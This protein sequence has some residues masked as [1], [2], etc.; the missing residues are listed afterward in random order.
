MNHSYLGGRVE[1]DVETS[2]TPN[3]VV[4]NFTMSTKH[5]EKRDFH[6]VAAWGEAAKIASLL[7]KGDMVVIEGRLQSRMVGEGEQRRE[8]TEVVAWTILPVKGRIEME[9]GNVANG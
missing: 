9:Q 5:R 2:N 1:S 6:N 4:A 8:K 7:R 3:S